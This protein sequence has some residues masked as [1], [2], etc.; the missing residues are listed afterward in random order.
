METLPYVTQ[1]P[2]PDQFLVVYCG[3]CICFKLRLSTMIPGKA[4]VRTNLG[5]ADI[6]RKEIINRIEKN[7]IKLAGGWYDIE[8]VLEID[9]VYKAVLPFHQIGSFQ[10]KCF[11]IPE[12]SAVPIWPTGG[13]CVLNV[14]PAGTCCA[15]II[16]NAF[17][18]QFGQSK[19]GVT[20]KNKFVSIVE[21]LDA[22]GY[23]VIP[24]S[25]KFR[26]LK[27]EVPFIFSDLGCRV[28][29][30]LP[31]H[32]TPT[33][34]ARMGRFGSPYA[35]L[36]FT[37][38][39]PALAVFDPSATP[40]EQFMELVDMVHFYNGYLFMDI[41]I[42]HTGW[43][44]SIH[45]THPE[46][47]IRGD[48]GEI[49]AP[50]AWG[51]VWA[52]LTKLDYSNKDLW[53]YMADV[54]LLWCHRGVDGF[55]CDAGYMIPVEAWE[56]MVAKVRV[57]YPETL[58]FLEGLGG[59]VQTTRD[60]LNKANL[61]WAYSEL[62]QNH[63]HEQIAA[64]L[65][66]AYEISTTCGH[67]IHFAETHDNNRLASI[68]TEYAKMRTALCALFSVCGGFGFANGVEWFATEKINVHESGSLNWGDSLNQVEYIARLTQ[69]LKIHP[70]FFGQAR[71]TLIQKNRSECLVLL[72]HN[73]VY[74]K[75]LL[76]LVNLD[77][78]I[79][80]RASWQSGETGIKGVLFY[81]L[82][83]GKPFNIEKN[84]D[85]SVIGLAP[86]QVLAL[87]PDP[88]DIKLL[89]K[90]RDDNSQAPAR[91]YL[92][93]LKAKV[94]SIHIE[95]KGYANLN[96][97]D[98]E[99]E[100]VLFARD[101]VEF[102]RLFNKSSKESRVVVLD[103]ERDLKRQL[104]IP[105]GF[106]LFIRCKN[107]F[108]A[109]LFDDTRSVKKSS[110]YEEGLSTPDKTGFFAFFS[111]KE[112]KKMSGEYTL[113]LRVFDPG[114]TRVE[115]V[116][117]LYLAPFDALSMRSSF[118]RKEIV[119]TPFLKLLATTRR[120]GMMRAAA[121]WSRLDSRYDAFLGANM[122]D[123][124][125]ENRWMVLSRCRIWAI[126]QG[127][128]R[129]LVPDCLEKFSFSYDHG[130]KWLFHVPTS[131]GKYYA[132][133]LH[134][135]M[136]PE[137][138]HICLTLVRKSSGSFSSAVLDDDR[139]IT[140]IIRPDIED[141]SF[142]EPV[143]AFTGPEKDWP[144]AIR[145]LNDGFFFSLSNNR[146]LGVFISKGEFVQAPEWQYMV[147]RPL[148]AQR[149]LDSESDLFSPGYFTVLARGGQTLRLDAAVVENCAQKADFDSQI[150]FFEPGSFEKSMPLSEAIYKSLDAFLVHRGEDKSVVAGYPWFLDWGRDSL[151]FCRSLIEVQRFSEAKS[152]LRLFGRFENHGT[153]P[154]MICGGDAKN[155]ETSDAPLW[156]FTCCKELVEKE[157]NTNFLDE[158]LDKRTIKQILLSIANSLIKGT[159]TGV[160][161]DPKTMLLYSPS[162]FTWMDTNF[163]AGSPR[164]GYPVEIQALWYN[165]LV[166]LGT[167][168][169]ANGKD[170]Q[171]RAIIV[172]TNVFDLFWKAEAGF[173]S[174]CLHSDGPGSAKTAVPDDAL[175]PNQLFLF[176]LGVIK[177]K[178]IARQCVETCQELLVPGGIRSLADRRLEYPLHIFHHDQLLKDPYHPY[179][180]EYRGDEDTER[181]PAYHNGTAWTWPFPVFCEA[182]AIVFGIHSHGTC[183]AWLGSVLAL[184]RKGAA[185]YIPEILDGDFPHTSRGC[186]AQAWG[187]SEVA[188]VMHKLLH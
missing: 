140:L 49:K 91:V 88:E 11:F 181:K 37:E 166:F 14:E 133:E 21:T 142:H 94:L 92:Q 101:P 57:E 119:N 9:S 46:W 64:Y 65:P 79:S 28:L 134:L 114:G 152:I 82:I 89:E 55:R 59:R 165:A 169:G 67:M 33:T 168:D 120:G 95:F 48:D 19:V 12:T 58:F 176:T 155:I 122:D 29:H 66:T 141:R 163:P 161:V 54:F 44:A 90:N 178:K 56:Y 35:A 131:E 164:Q 123:K 136:D 102:I 75:K 103:V 184:M 145:A 175:R 150:D 125:P 172:Q 78:K 40:L 3:D 146:Q 183:L 132:L 53:K 31:I 84:G 93:K 118:T 143:K 16:Y 98:L 24:E 148:E 80:N 97:I 179:S 63:T 99:Q 105:P 73:E 41:A 162:H 157:G 23:T 42:N 107:S 188:R 39:D 22:N 87:T 104:M 6:S 111:P 110:G 159:P 171:K 50:G 38:V 154:N 117:L 130:G 5:S 149:G 167:I 85:T 7:D 10:A 121:W 126:F 76:I 2:L 112:R 36:N 18:R 69:I 71:L 20:L 96:G 174:D 86:G 70:A 27:K 156:F 34:Y 115:K 129:E 151:I 113:V 160:V 25:G 180:G 182:W 147:H 170:W 116:S 60:L 17:V 45:E 47:L 74:G 128:S 106:F 62:F 15:N 77:C 51:V 72:R 83:S 32:P 135:A 4:W 153:L 68:S 186:D 187:V 108:R 1:S 138:N 26:D 8:M 43:A 144:N 173:F 137:D 158:I 100:A 177:N 30:L 185:G 127:Y 139:E 81:D 109:E 61:N 52:D 13:N 124:M